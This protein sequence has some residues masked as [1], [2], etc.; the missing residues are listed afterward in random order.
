MRVKQLPPAEQL[1]DQL[2]MDLW[3]GRFYRKGGSEPAGFVNAKGYGVVKLSS[4][5]FFNHRLVW[6]WV[7]GEDPRG[8]ID[9]VNQCEEE[10]KC[11]MFFGLDD[12]SH[13]YNL[14]V[15]HYNKCK[16]GV[17]D[18]KR[19]LVA[20]V[21]Y[22]KKRGKYLARIKNGINGT[23]SFDTE[24]EA[25][26]KYLELCEEL[27]HSNEYKY[28]FEPVKLVP[29]LSLDY[30]YKQ[31]KRPD[32]TRHWNRPKRP[33]RNLLSTKTVRPLVLRDKRL[34]KEFREQCRKAGVNPAEKL[35]ELVK[36]YLND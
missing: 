11:D 14:L 22:D 1:W 8:V 3:S 23:Y 36:E 7:T 12:V 16:N 34:L 26:L 25:R 32:R 31:E 9:H 17:R 35:A 27:L 2:E 24:E 5:A 33:R 29:F 15:A 21:R 18:E 30:R 20:G 19:G 10:V 4:I 28:G 13:G 6:K